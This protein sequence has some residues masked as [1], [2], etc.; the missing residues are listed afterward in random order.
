[1]MIFAGGGTIQLVSTWFLK[2]RC[3]DMAASLM[4]PKEPKT[5]IDTTLTQDGVAA[6]AKV[7]GDA[8]ADIRTDV[9]SKINLAENIGYRHKTGT[10]DCDLS[11]LKEGEYLL[12]APRSSFVSAFKVETGGVVCHDS[13]MSVSGK[14]LTIK[15]L[16][17]YTSVHAVKIK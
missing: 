16:Q 4:R 12:I 2:A 8:V 5:E 10:C 9:S 13:N 1:M 11:K 15:N 14:T 17:W 7:V 6:D 3:A